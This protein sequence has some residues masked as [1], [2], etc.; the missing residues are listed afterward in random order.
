M[1]SPGGGVEGHGPRIPEHGQSPDG[2]GVSTALSATVAVSGYLF[3]QITSVIPE[4][5]HALSLRMAELE[6]TRDELVYKR[7]FVDML[8][9]NVMPAPETLRRLD[10][11]DA[12]ID[13]CCPR[14][15]RREPR[16]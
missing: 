12:Q 7:E 5:A 16:P 3:H 6:A 13:E 4:R 9:A 8:R 10:Q 11:I 2:A 1:E 15:G 14:N